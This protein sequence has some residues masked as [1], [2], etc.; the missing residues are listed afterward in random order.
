M[1]STAAAK[2][3]PY[4]CIGLAK[5][6]LSKNHPS[7]FLVSLHEPC[8]CFNQ[9]KKKKKKKGMK[10]KRERG[11][12]RTKT[13]ACLRNAMHAERK[14]ISC[15]RKGML[16]SNKAMHKPKKEKEK[17][18]ESSKRKAARVQCC[19]P[20]RDLRQEKSIIVI[21]SERSANA[22]IPNIPPKFIRI[23]RLRP[24]RDVF[25]QPIPTG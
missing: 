22:K 15:H 18:S 14:R 5:D 4:A 17:G 2:T 7:G 10:K 19:G 24:C 11:I 1:R 12:A 8:A 9:S 20:S 6:R 3:C 13:R 23:L 16:R 25:D 21:A